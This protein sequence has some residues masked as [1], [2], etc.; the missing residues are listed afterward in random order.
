MKRRWLEVTLAAAGI[1]FLSKAAWDIYRYRSFQHRLL[2]G[3]P[4]VQSAASSNASEHA[5]GEPAMIGQL[6]VPRLRILAAVVEG[7][8]ENSLDVAVGHIKGTALFGSRGNAVVA[9]HRDTVF[10]PL[11][12]IRRG[13]HILVSTGRKY[14]YS[15]E[16]TQI[17][18]PDDTRTLQDTDTAILT[19]VTCYPFRHVGP[20]P[21]RFVVVAKLLGS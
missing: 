17:V 1:L 11:R 3:H 13:D 4:V 10:W 5:S 2:F 20:S 8:D 15:V 12:N 21:K 7:D 16:Q 18:D 14:V 6:S 9:G 19:L